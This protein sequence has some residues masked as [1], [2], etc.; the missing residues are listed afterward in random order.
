MGQWF[1]WY[2]WIWWLLI[3]PTCSIC[4][5]TVFKPEWNLTRN[6]LLMIRMHFDSHSSGKTPAPGRC[7]GSHPF[8]CLAL[9][10][11][12]PGK[13]AYICDSSH[14]LHYRNL[15]SDLLRPDELSTTL[16]ASYS[17]WLCEKKPRGQK[18]KNK[19]GQTC[20]LEILAQNKLKGVG[21]VI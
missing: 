13:Q 21:D 4:P 17:R 9:A 2:P 16:T 18:T 19:C 14:R 12:C 3:L 10:W 15:W 20:N 8:P 11:L 6:S 1:P 5:N 7:W